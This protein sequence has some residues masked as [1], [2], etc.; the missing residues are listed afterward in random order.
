MQNSAIKQLWLRQQKSKIL[1]T[2]SLLLI[3]AVTVLIAA[4]FVINLNQTGT[5]DNAATPPRAFSKEYICAHSIFIYS[6]ILEFI[7]AL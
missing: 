3:G 1:L 5:A 2:T 6:A 7:N 4:P